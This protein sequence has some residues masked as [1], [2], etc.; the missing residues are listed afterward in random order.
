MDD[1]N[2]CVCNSTS[3]N[4]FGSTN[5]VVAEEASMGGHYEPNNLY[6][7]TWTSP[8]SSRLLF[9]AGVTMYQ[10]SWPFYSQK[11]AATNGISVTDTGLGL[12]YRAPAAFIMRLRSPQ[13]TA[14]SRRR[15][16]PAPTNTRLAFLYS[17]AT[18]I[19]P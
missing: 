13:Q 6:Q 11:D 7:A 14:G 9:Q 5:P 8:V 2:N 12:T 19:R 17:T 3:A 15:T 10:A 4:L 1:E 16:S 18:S